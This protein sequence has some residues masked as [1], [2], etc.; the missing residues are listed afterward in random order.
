MRPCSTA[1]NGTYTCAIQGS[2]VVTWNPTKTVTVTAPNGTRAIQTHLGQ[3][4]P[5]TRGQRVR[6][7]AYPI[8]FAV[9]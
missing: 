8:L 3:R 2:G 7:G 1:K 5:A 4:I 6:V 9:R